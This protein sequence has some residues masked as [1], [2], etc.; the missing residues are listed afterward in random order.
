[1]PSEAA[2]AGSSPLLF[3]TAEK[4]S[5]YMTSLSSATSLISLL[6]STIL[7]FVRPSSALSLTSAETGVTDRRYI[8]ASG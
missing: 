4:I 1:M 3:A 8:S 6:I 2:E 5:Q 7:S